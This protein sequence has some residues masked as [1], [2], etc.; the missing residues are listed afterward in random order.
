MQHTAIL[1]TERRGSK[2]QIKLTDAQRLCVEGMKKLGWDI[3]FVRM[4]QRGPLVVVC[5]GDAMCT[6]DSLGNANFSSE[7]MVRHTDAN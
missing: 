7:V 4:T 2:A 3:W 1:P 5:R 6:I